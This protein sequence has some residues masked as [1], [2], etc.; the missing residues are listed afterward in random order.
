MTNKKNRTFLLLLVLSLF[1]LSNNPFAHHSTSHYAEQVSELEGTLVEIRWRNPHVYLFL[2][3]E[4]DQGNKSIWELEAG[5]LYN[6]TRAGIT[7]D[8]FKVGDKVRIA[9]NIS[10]TYPNKF[11]LENILAA[12]G[13]EYI[14]VARSNPRWNDTA[15][16]GRRSWSNEAKEKTDIAQNNAGIFRV[17]S[18]ATRGTEL[19]PGLTANRLVAVATEE[20]LSGR[21]EWDYSFDKNCLAPGMPRANHSPHPH[22]FI[23]MGDTIH[24]FS[25]EFHATRVIQMDTNHKPETQPFSAL[26]YSFGRWKNDHTLVIE[27]SRINFPY[28]DLTGIKQSDQVTV[29]E[30]YVLSEDQTKLEYTVVVNDPIMLKEPHIK[31]G[32]WLDLNEIIDKETSCLPIADIE[33]N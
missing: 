33:N 29:K 4:N 16:G 10:N 6:I 32:V 22:Q 5:T 27:T 18:P 11:W 9:G 12:N 21:S 23:D 7:E 2:E 14:F 1:Y 15:I 17:W 28:M 25:E 3:V 13:S 8:L 20:A 31:R 26:G 19:S 24:I 30:T